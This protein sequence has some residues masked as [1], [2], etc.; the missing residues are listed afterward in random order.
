[1][2]DDSIANS[3]RSALQSF[4]TVTSLAPTSC[5]VS[6]QEPLTSISEEEARFKVWS[7]NIGAHNSG[8]RSLQYRLRDASHLQK[9]IVALLGDLIDLLED[10]KA[11]VTGDKVPWDQLE[12]DES[13]DDEPLPADV[14]ADDSELPTT[15]MT[16]IAAGVS[17]VVNC[18]LR[19]SVA[20]RNPA[21]H[22]RFTTFVPI[23][24]SHYEPFDIQHVKS[25]FGDIEPFLTER[26]GKA[27]S[28]RRQYFKYRQSHHLKLSHGLDDEPKDSESTIASSI[29]GH[30]KTTRF[31]LTSMDE[32]AASDSGVTQTSFAS[33]SADTEKIRIPPLPEEAE[34]GPF[35]CPFCYM[36]IIATSTIS[37]N[38][39]SVKVEDGLSCPMCR[40]TLHSIKEYQ[41]HVGR[42]QE[43]L[44]LF[45]LP[46]IESLEDRE[47]VE[48]DSLSGQSGAASEDIAVPKDESGELFFSKG[49]L[50]REGGLGGPLPN[51][52]TLEVKEDF[53]SH[54]PI[55]ISRN[56]RQDSALV[57]TDFS[58]GYQYT[59]PAS[60][61]RDDF[62]HSQPSYSPHPE[63]S[64]S[65]PPSIPTAQVNVVPSSIGGHDKFNYQNVRPTSGDAVLVDYLDD[66]RPYNGSDSASDT[67]QYNS[68]VQG[69]HKNDIPS[70]SPTQLTKFPE[71]NQLGYKD[72]RPPPP[73]TEAPAKSATPAPPWEDPEKIRL[74]AEIAAFKAMEEKAKAA[75]KEKEAEA[76]IRKE[77]EEAFHRRM[78]DMRLAQE[79]AK[80]KI[81]RAG[82]EAEKAAR[83]RMKAERKAEEERAREDL[84]KVKADETTTEPHIQEGIGS[85]YKELR[86]GH[87][88]EEQSDTGDNSNPELVPTRLASVTVGEERAKAMHIRKRTKTGCL[89]CRKRRIECDEERP[90]CNNCIKSKRQCE[91]YDQRVIFKDP[92]GAIQGG[93][94]GPAYYPPGSSHHV[95]HLQAKTSAQGHLPRIAPKPNPYDF[96][97]STVPPEPPVPYARA[98]QDPRQHY[99]EPPFNGQHA[100][101]IGESSGRNPTSD[102]FEDQA[103]G[104]VPSLSRQ[105]DERAPRQ[106]VLK[107]PT[108]HFPEDPNPIREGVSRLKDDKKARE[109]PPGA[110]WTKISRKIVSAEVLTIGGERFEVREDFLI[111]LRPLSHEEIQAYADST[112]ALRG[113][114]DF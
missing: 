72:T 71:K 55:D 47:N 85:A 61:V 65:P 98:V 39:K 53:G 1:M 35:E 57:P 62:G 66:G 89:T 19:L 107:Q 78:E 36:M 87:H 52:P 60:L 84:S 77:A 7:G 45:A 105:A 91:G 14:D 28:R 21:P 63:P 5:D 50:I 100:Q 70:D 81:E 33:S 41:R 112:K 37:W 82:L 109:I 46:S 110:K 29:P 64:P 83:E 113:K 111:V 96:S 80:E 12:D 88:Q 42:H 93:P 24:A 30:A 101:D 38:I 17:D 40:E 26:L 8:R 13:L 58:E 11:I 51:K 69:D 18:L 108:S 79:E 95:G 16:Q 99:A 76:Q 67:D 27:I 34:D 15:E 10:A 9:Q 49:S 92:M 32:D 59:T 23:E 74:E 20:I 48:E 25:K 114:S 4:Q 97:A 3:V 2:E 103:Q 43:Q 94:F 6:Y 75:E 73:P 104:R 22:D 54:P 68:I 31:N 44:A 86:F 106:G 102:L 56:P 90:I